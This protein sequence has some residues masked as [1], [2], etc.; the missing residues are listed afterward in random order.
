MA[1]G[2][3]DRFSNVRRIAL[4]LC[5]LL[6]ALLTV[7]ASANA[8]TYARN[9]QPERWLEW[10]KALFA[11]EVTRVESQREAD[12]PVDVISLRVVETFK[13]PP[14]ESAIVRMPA[15]VR[16][17]CRLELPQPG[18]QLLVG[19]DADDN[20]AWVPLKESYSAALRAKAGK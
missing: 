9:V 18:E 5:A 17:N 7:S 2:C 16:V 10:S 12:R 6:A 14:G 8:C 11:A 20:S 4:Q 15:R 13:G 1:I 3:A 19:L